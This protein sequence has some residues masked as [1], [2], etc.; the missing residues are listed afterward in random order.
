MTH[1][2]EPGL[3]VVEV[4][5]RRRFEVR[6]SDGTMIGQADYDRTGPVLA[7]THTEVDG[8]FEGRGVASFLVQQALDEVR[9]SG[10][11]IVPYC[12]Y[13]RA[14]LHRH[15]DYQDLLAPPPAEPPARP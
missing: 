6:T 5:E 3:H 7:F 1:S 11:T 9:A 8:A 14:W 13:V 4:P 2:P 12:P 15:P 10:R